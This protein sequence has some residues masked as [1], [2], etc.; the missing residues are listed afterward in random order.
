MLKTIYYFLS[1]CLQSNSCEFSNSS[2][3]EGAIYIHSLFSIFILAFVFIWKRDLWLATHASFPGWRI[4]VSSNHILWENRFILSV[5]LDVIF[6]HHST[7]PWPSHFRYQKHHARQLFFSLKFSI[8][9]MSTAKAT[10]WAASNPG[11]S[12]SALRITSWTRYKTNWPEEKHYWKWCS[13]V[14]RTSLKG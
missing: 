7:Y 11:D 10:R 12:W 5:I 9:W 3:R 8:T 6:C 1:V 2:T 14:Q 13:P 4:L